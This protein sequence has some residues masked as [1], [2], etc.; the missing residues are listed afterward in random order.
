MKRF[1]QFFL[2][3]IVL[4]VPSEN[5]DKFFGGVSKLFPKLSTKQKE[6]LEALL[7]ATSN[8]PLGQRA[9]LLATAY[10]ETGATMQPIHEYGGV[11]YFDKYDTG[12]LA[13]ALGNTPEKDG[14]GYKYRGRG[15]VQ[16]TGLTNYRRAS[17]QLEADFVN[18]PDLALLPNH[19]ADILVK[20]CVEGWFTGKKLNDY[21]NDKTTDYRNARRVVNGLD[22]ADLIASYARV[23]QQAL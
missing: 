5:N 1:V 22:Y 11:R 10:H 15:Y 9:Y 23:F 12:K 18:S 21:I 8:L 14:D 20:G 2:N 3:W 7:K 19:A 6:G 16:L 4:K 13:K 17:K